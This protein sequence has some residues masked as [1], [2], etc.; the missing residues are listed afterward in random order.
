[1]RRLSSTAR[2]LLISS[3]GLPGFSE[4]MAADGDTNEFQYR[5][6]L[7]DED[8][9]PLKVLADGN[10]DRYRIKS[11]QFSFKREMNERFTLTVEGIHESMSGSSP[12][13][14]IPEP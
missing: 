12:W 7:Y 13:Y 11:H 1:M 8:P 5:Y 2:S 9:L 4:L 10:P 3:L 6:T 14:V